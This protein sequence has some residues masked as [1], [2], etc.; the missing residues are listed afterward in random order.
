MSGLASADIWSGHRG[1][2]WCVEP[3]QQDMDDLNMVEVDEQMCEP[4]PKRTLLIISRRF[5]LMRSK[6][7]SQR[8]DV[9]SVSMMR[10]RVPVK[11]ECFQSRLSFEGNIQALLICS[12]GRSVP[13][14]VNRISFQIRL[15]FFSREKKSR[16][17]TC[18][19][20]GTQIR[21]LKEG[22]STAFWASTVVPA[23]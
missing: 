3:K 1:I 21:S 8:L 22:E 10:I 12:R 5:Q 17:R 18:R 2:I 20:T 4:R 7:R 16:H 14:N 15:H 11:S 19:R 6:R 23:R 13:V 9:P